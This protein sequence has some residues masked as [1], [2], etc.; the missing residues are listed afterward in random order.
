MVLLI[1]DMKHDSW[2]NGFNENKSGILSIH[3]CL[4]VDWKIRN[5]IKNLLKL[6][7]VQS[8]IK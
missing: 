8:M 5:K 7:L 4:V 2:N 1:G 6:C 3:I